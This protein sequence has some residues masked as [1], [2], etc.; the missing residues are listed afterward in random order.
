MTRIQCSRAGPLFAGMGFGKDRR[1]EQNLSSQKSYGEQAL[2]PIKDLI[3]E[4]SGMR[5]FFDSNEEW[6]PLFRSLAGHSYVPAMS[7]METSSTMF[8]FNKETK[9]WRRLDAI[10]TKED[11][12]AVL[13]AFLDAIQK[14]LI[15]IPVDETTNEDDNDL[16]FIEEGRRIL[17]CSRFHVVQGM[18][19][20]SIQSFDN[21]FATCWSEITELRQLNEIDNGSLIVVP[22]LKYDDLRRFVD[23]NLQRPLQWLGIHGDFE[24]ASLEHGGLGVVRLIHKLSDIP[25]DIPEQ[26]VE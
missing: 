24:V 9:P 1:D 3:D 21:L 10:P 17:V 22:G 18:E 2:T 15:D 19:R 7:F 4:E 25:T 26:P 12:K 23:M 6:Q 16:H 5:E 14:S 8:E 13:A 11:D 20:G